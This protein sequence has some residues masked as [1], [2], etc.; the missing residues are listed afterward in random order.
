MTL[1][2][3][4]VLQWDTVFPSFVNLGGVDVTW[5]HALPTAGRKAK[6]HN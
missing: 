4:G 5:L 3:D 6:S 1:R 2:I